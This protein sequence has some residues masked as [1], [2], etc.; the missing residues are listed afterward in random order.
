[1]RQT[2]LDIADFLEL[3]P[4]ADQHS[5]VDLLGGTLEKRHELG[6]VL[7]KFVVNFRVVRLQVVHIHLQAELAHGCRE[8]SISSSG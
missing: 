2:Y 4:F 3:L 7:A 8:Q 1:M 5:S 6:G